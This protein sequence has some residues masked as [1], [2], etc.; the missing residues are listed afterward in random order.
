MPVRTTDG[1]VRKLMDLDDDFDTA[2]FIE[3]ANSLVNDVCTGSGYSDSKLELIERWL[4][5]HMCAILDPPANIETADQVTAHY[6]S[7]VAL[8]LNL[9]RWGQQAMRL[10]TDGNLAGLDNAM[11]KVVVPLDPSGGFK[12]KITWLGK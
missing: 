7:K 10:D 5:A 4:S 6:D 8:G 1:A 3:A 12:S 11:K 2:P 9:T